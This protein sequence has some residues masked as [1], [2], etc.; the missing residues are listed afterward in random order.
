ML[1]QKIV[2]I[3]GA[4]SGVGRMTALACAREGAHVAVVDLDAASGEET[5]RPVQTTDAEAVFVRADGGQRP[6]RRRKGSH[7][8]R[9]A[10][11]VLGIVVCWLVAGSCAVAADPVVNYTKLARSLVRYPHN[12]VIKVGEKGAWDDQ[13]L[14]CFAVLDDGDKFFCYSDG[15]QFGKPKNLGMATSKDGIHWTKYEQNPLFPGS[16]PH[17]I[18]VGDTFRLYYPH[19]GGMQMRI[20]QDGF[21]WGEPRKVL[22][23]QL[24]PCVI[25]VGENKYHLYYCAGGKKTIDNKE[26]WEFKNYLA[27]SPDGITWQNEPGPI[28]PLGPQGS[29]DSQSH[30]GPYVLKLADGYHM[31]YLG[32]GPY[33]GDKVAWRIGHATSADG[34]KWTRSGEDPVL[35]IGKPGDWDSGTFLHFNIIFRDGK[36]HFWYAAAPTEHGDETKMKIEIGYGTSMPLDATSANRCHKMSTLSTSLSPIPRS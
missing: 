4:G 12:P 8:K 29:W 18:K 23:S 24:D 14:G 15:A 1:K 6:R 2:L 34:L 35:D 30:A 26:R 32:S 11:V 13:T 10:Q 3:T 22:E 19:A 20:S 9:L 17:A 28:L 25:R 33:M 7:M 27:T 36:F 5:E 21:R 16:M 31:W